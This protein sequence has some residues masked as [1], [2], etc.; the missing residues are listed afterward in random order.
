MNGINYIQTFWTPKHFLIKYFR[1]YKTAVNSI[2]SCHNPVGIR[3][4]TRLRLGLQLWAQIQTE[5]SRNPFYFPVAKKRLKVVLVFYLHVPIT[6]KK[7]WPSLK[8]QKYQYQSNS[9]AVINQ[10]LLY[11]DKGFTTSNNFGLLTSTTL[12][13][14]Y[15]YL[16]FFLSVFPRIQTEYSP[17]ARKCESEKFQTRTLFT[18]YYWIPS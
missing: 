4:L 16:E 7:D 6:M 10:F 14:K 11:G 8:N 13:E 18:Q 2:F 15:P 1:I 5:L 12:R 9:I 3:L 17:N